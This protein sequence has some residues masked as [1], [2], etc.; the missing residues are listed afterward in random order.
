VKTHRPI[1]ESP[2]GPMVRIDGAEYLYFVGTG[3]LGLQ[4]HPEVIRAACDAAEHFG[5]HSATS[6]AGFGNTP[7][8]LL[9]ERRA[10]E[11]FG[12]EASFYFPTGYA[13][14]S[15]LLRAIETSFD[16]L[17]IDEYSHYCEFEAAAQSG[18]PLFRFHHRDATDLADSLRKHLQPG[19]R[20]LVMTDGVFSVRGTI[21]PLA[22]YVAALANYPGAGFLVDDAHGVGV[23]GHR[24]RGTLEHFGLFDGMYEGS[25]NADVLAAGGG[26]RAFLCATLSKALGG[27]GGIIPGSEAFIEH[28]RR[29]SHW[30]DGVT[31]PPAP[32]T[33]A[34]ARAIELV[35]ADSDLRT[36]LWSNV[37]RL[38]DG[39]RAMGFD[40]GDTPV[41][42]ICLEIGDA[43]N[44]RR[45]QQELMHRGIAVAYMAAYS[46]LSAAGG[47]RIAVFATHTDEMIQQ[48][49][50][51]LSRVV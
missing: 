46:G 19:Q 35:Q 3:Y 39:L 13:G 28:A 51:E 24:G 31:S 38:K 15:I 4:A 8:T 5:I 50:A 26:C 10:A 16:V 49:L 7:P 42:V 12:C 45:I 14:S 43:E 21:A 23:L 11:F 27:Y 32:V 9:V 1:A 47:L 25:V 30:Y 37:R 36:R 2:P 22:D 18:R 34:S 41:P 33:A 40:V 17:F 20:P 48:F 6:R 29:C 44:M